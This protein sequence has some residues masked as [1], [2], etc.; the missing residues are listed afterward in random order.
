MSV[1][2]LKVTE[3]LFIKYKISKR[4]AKKY[5]KSGLVEY[6]TKKVN[7]DIT[8][9]NIND[10]ELK[11]EKKSF[12]INVE[13]YILVK[14]ENTLFIYKPPF[15]HTERIRLEDD[16]CISDL[17]DNY[18]SDFR[19]ISRLDYETD[20]IIPAIK[21]NIKIINQEKMYLAWVN[22]IVDKNFTIKNR[23]DAAKKRKVIVLDEEG[24]NEL[25]ITVLKNLPDKTLLSIK[26]ESAHRHQI[27]ASLAHYGYP[28][29]G[30]KLY[31]K[32]NY[33]RLLLQCY[34][35]SINGISYKLPE[36]KLIDKVF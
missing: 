35:T 26:I 20:G 5:L 12:D 34:Y 7:K 6:R 21:E 28:I 11:V 19:L 1:S 15:V 8:I 2:A 32:D 13:N 36:D 14:T 30:D 29:I 17:I 24:D 22:G 9:E 25:S 31:G 3:A 33:S 4:V 10:L 27:R 23:I 16:I 18:F